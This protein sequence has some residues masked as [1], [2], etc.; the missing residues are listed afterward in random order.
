M[1]QDIGVSKDLNENFKRHLTNSGEP[2]DIDFSIQVLF[3][4]RSALTHILNAKN[5]YF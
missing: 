1:F 2:L 5:V 4:L 3:D